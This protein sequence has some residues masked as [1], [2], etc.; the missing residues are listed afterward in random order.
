MDTPVPSPLTSSPRRVHLYGWLTAVATGLG[1]L[2]SVAEVASQPPRLSGSFG[3]LPLWFEPTTSAGPG[4]E[5]PI[6]VC[7]G[8]GYS[9]RLA[10]DGADILLR[11]RPGRMREHR[12]ALATVDP[13]EG[14]GAGTAGAWFR[15]RFLGANRAAQAVPE[16]KLGTRVNYL[17]GSHPGDW[18]R[19]VPT[20]ERIRYQG[21]YPGIDVVYYGSDRQLEHDFI[22]APGADPGLIRVHFEGADQVELAKNGDLVIGVG[23]AETRLRRPY[24]YQDMPEGRR[25][26]RGDFT[27]EGEAERVI[28]LEIGTYDRAWPLV[29]DPILVYSTFLGGLGYDQGSGIAVDAT[30]HVY[31]TGETASVDFPV[32]NALWPTNSGGFGGATNPLGNEAFVAKFDPTGRTLVYATYIGGNGVDAGIGIAVDDA[33]HA[34]ATGLTASTNFPVTSNAFQ[35]QLPG[36]PFLGFYPSSAFV[37]KLSPSGDELL[38]STYLGG[39]TD[40]LGLAIALDDQ[41]AAYVTG[42]TLSSD[43]PLHEQAPRFGGGSDAFVAKLTLTEN[44]LS[45]STLLGGAGP[46][47]GQGIAVDTAGHAIVVGQTASA[48]FPITN[49]VQGQ[50]RGGTFDAF[51]SKLTP[52]GMALVFSTY[53]GGAAADEAY[54][55]ALDREGNSYITGYTTSANF[56]NTNAVFGTIAGRDAFLTKLSPAGSLIASTFLGG[57]SNDDGWAVAVDDVGRATVVGTTFSL[58]FP[59]TN[60]IQSARSGNLDLFV[61]RFNPAGDALE[62]STYLGG[63]NQDEAR[64]VAVDTMGAIYV[65][66]FTLSTDFPLGPAL[67]TFQPAYGGGTGDAY[68][69]KIQPAGVTLQI[70][71]L[72]GLVELSWPAG[73]EG[74]VLESAAGLRGTDDWSIVPTQPLVIESRQVVT[75]PPQEQTLFFRLRRE[76]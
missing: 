64:A 51:A 72:P 10:P 71:S 39:S 12:R 7:R 16:G 17:R 22:V 34:Y 59:V 74:F 69:M 47:F 37:L 75:V 15:M 30:G 48:N 8:Q 40:D 29:I 53:L 63:G 43:F 24:L 38:Y 9:I 56:P 70:E 73:L 54:G 25:E 26:V 44:R 68:V 19:N 2:C 36:Q 61:T 46:D 35:P 31:V 52:D 28:L 66:G 49:A 50:F 14:G 58:D 23:E 76:D 27:I 33:G 62:F 18:R 4:S 41:G 1:A 20:Y 60:A 65:T 5:E 55:V 32:A 21:V 11:P 13:A 6:Y 3:Q 42:N 57:S 67:A 45:Y